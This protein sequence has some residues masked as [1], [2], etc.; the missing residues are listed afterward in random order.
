MIPP[1]HTKK[2]FV[3]TRR[4]K[5]RPKRGQKRKQELD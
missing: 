1:A 5:K 3:K 4:G 2:G